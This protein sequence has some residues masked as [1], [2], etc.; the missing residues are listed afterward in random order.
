MI[1]ASRKAELIVLAESNDAV[2][3]LLTEVTKLEESL[4]FVNMALK[5]SLDRVGAIAPEIKMLVVLAMM[6]EK[7]IPELR[8][9][10][11]A[12]IDRLS[13]KH[14]LRKPSAQE[15]EELDRQLLDMIGKV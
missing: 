11:D 12:S 1:T 13:L 3:E 14:G 5:N 6:E 8:P 15:E 10:L 9:Y 7:E 4:D 2:K